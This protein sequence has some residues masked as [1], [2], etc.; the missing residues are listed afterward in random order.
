MA[1]AHR[2]M[3]GAKG[4][5]V[6]KDAEALG[7]LESVE[8]GILRLDHFRERGRVD[9]DRLEH[10]IGGSAV[11][12]RTVDQQRA[13]VD[14][15][16]LPGEVEFVALRVAAEVIV[17]VEQQDARLR[18]GIAIEERGRQATDAGTDHDKVKLLV[19][20]ERFEL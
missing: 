14:Q 10:A 15:A 4:L 7:F 18:I 19:E 16:H 9:A 5:L 13:T 6:E 20:V 3:V 8:I 12:A 2:K 17:V 11:W 1:V